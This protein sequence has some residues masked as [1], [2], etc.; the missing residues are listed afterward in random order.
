MNCAG[1]RLHISYVVTQQKLNY[2]IRLC[3]G[4]KILIQILRKNGTTSV[5]FWSLD[6]GAVALDSSIMSSTARVSKYAKD[7]HTQ[8]QQI[9][10]HTLV[11]C[12]AVV[13]H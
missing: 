3:V 1:L 10:D 13:D 6:S 12:G 4:K 5:K 7:N 2:S 11:L 9:Q 8:E